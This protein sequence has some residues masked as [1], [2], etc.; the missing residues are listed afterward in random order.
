MRNI[1]FIAFLL[2]LILAIDAVVF[3]GH[4][5][6]AAWQESKYQAQQFNQ[7]IHSWLG[8]MGL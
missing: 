8:T 4:Y 7:Q 1:I 5:R 2:G 6:D 3:D